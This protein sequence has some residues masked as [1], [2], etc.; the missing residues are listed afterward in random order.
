MSPEQ[1]RGS[2]DIDFRADIWQLCVVLYETLT[3]RVPFEGE[4]YNALMRAIVE[5]DPE[6]LPLD[7]QIDQRLAELVGWG[8]KKTREDR[9]DSVRALGRGLS[10]WLLERGVTEDITGAALAPKW[11]GQ[12]S[13]AGSTEGTTGPR[14]A[15]GARAG[16]TRPVW[17]VLAGACLVAAWLL[18]RGISSQRPASEPRAAGAL[19]AEPRSS[20]DR[21]L[22]SAAIVTIASSVASPIASASSDTMQEHPALSRSATAKSA[23]KPHERKTPDE[24]RPHPPPAPSGRVV[25]D[26]TRELLQ[27][28]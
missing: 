17:L 19:V 7:D 27:A 6:P 5:D 3:T 28:Y 1:A 4:N 14:L 21:P 20:I 11:L 13:R 10:T 26:E 23:S 9:P 24:A 25:H 12:A 16:E 15:P 22:S 18:V 8:L 2:S